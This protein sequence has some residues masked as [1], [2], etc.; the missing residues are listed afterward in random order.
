MSRLLSKHWSGLS[1]ILAIGFA[2]VPL[3]G[4][5]ATYT[6]TDLNHNGG[7][8]S[9]GFGISG[10]QAVGSSAVTG[11]LDHAALWVGTASSI[12]DLNP[13]GFDM[14]VAYSISGNR[15]A[16]YG[17]GGVTG[18]QTH[19]LLWSGSAAGFVD[20]NPTGFTISAAYGVSGNQQV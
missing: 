1:V 9:G 4:P 5:A 3:A 10:A 16:G 11:N 19:A 2:S 15:E 18:G 12:V 6:Y 7:T 14:S 20:L 13:A 17:Y 8:T